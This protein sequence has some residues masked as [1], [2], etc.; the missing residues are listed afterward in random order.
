MI[1][2]DF[3]SIEPKLGEISYIGSK[4][5]RCVADMH[6]LGCHHCCFRN[7]DVNC[8]KLNCTSRTRF[9]GLNV[10]FVEAWSIK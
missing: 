10:H 8:Y 4:I 2:D 1:K 3:K 7:G 6:D 9:D 5:V